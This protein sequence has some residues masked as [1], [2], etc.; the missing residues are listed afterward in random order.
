MANIKLLNSRDKVQWLANNGELNVKD[1][2]VE[3]DKINHRDGPWHQI[4]K[5]KI[6]NR[7]KIFLWKLGNSVLQ[8]RVRLRKFITSI[9]KKCLF[10]NE[11]EETIVHIFWNCNVADSTWL[12]IQEWWKIKVTVKHNVT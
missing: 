4:W 6:P 7:I 2:Y 12:D 8:V 5:M 9:D 3:L 11:V 1:L 10:C